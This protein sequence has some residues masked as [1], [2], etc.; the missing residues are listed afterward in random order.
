ML[1]IQEWKKCYKNSLYMLLYAC[2]EVNELIIIY[3]I[4]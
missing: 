1:T 2:S 4:N 3:S